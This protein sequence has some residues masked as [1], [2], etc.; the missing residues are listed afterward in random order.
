MGK[1]MDL[2]KKTAKVVGTIATVI[3][4][5]SGA[6]EQNNGKNTTSGNNG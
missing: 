6:L 1:K 2:F 3:T 4:A 5:V